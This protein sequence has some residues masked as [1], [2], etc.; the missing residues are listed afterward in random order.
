MLVTVKFS[1]FYF[2]DKKN[3]EL[4]FYYCTRICIFYLSPLMGSL[5]TPNLF[6]PSKLPRNSDSCWRFCIF[7]QV[8]RQ[9]HSAVNMPAAASCA[10]LLSTLTLILQTNVSF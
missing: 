10:L 6:R 9:L 3:F 4:F 2:G 7:S 1:L 5:Q 8:H